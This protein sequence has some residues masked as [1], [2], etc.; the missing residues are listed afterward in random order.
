MNNIKNWNENNPPNQTNT[1]NINAANKTALNTE[2]NVMKQ[3]LLFFKNDILKDFRK[4]EEK[5]NLKIT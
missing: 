1:S 5:L 4:M 2:F 3:D